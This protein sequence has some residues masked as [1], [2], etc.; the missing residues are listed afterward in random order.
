MVY[1]LK[2][3]VQSIFCCFFGEEECTGVY[4]KYTSNAGVSSK[5]SGVKVFSLPLKCSEVKVQSC[6][7]NR[8]LSKIQIH[9]NGT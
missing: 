7:K 9:Q 5:C 2:S 1:T 6:S 3:E 4:I 8:N